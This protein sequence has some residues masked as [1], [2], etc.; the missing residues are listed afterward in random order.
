MTDIRLYFRTSLH[1]TVP[2]AL[3][4]HPS[5]LATT[6]ACAMVLTSH[7]LIVSPLEAAYPSIIRTKLVASPVQCSVRCTVESQ[8]VKR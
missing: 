6:Q 8:R 5:V 1:G 7:Q 3:P 2:A 4:T